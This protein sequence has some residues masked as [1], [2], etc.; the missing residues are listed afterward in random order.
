[1]SSNYVADDFS[2]GLDM[3]NDRSKL[4]K[5]GKYPLLINARSRNNR[6]RAVNKPRQLTEGLPSASQGYK[7]QGLY[8]AGNIGLVFV[9][10]N[11]FTCNFD[12]GEAF[13]KLEKF[14][15]SGDVDQLYMELI[16][17]ST[18]NYQRKAIDFTKPTDGVELFNSLAAPSPVGALVQDGINQP[19]IIFSDGNCRETQ[20]YY[21]WQNTDNGREYVPIGKQMVHSGDKLYITDGRQ[22]FQSVSGRPLDFMIIVDQN[23]DKAEFAADGDASNFS[24]RIFYELIN[25]LAKVNTDGEAGFYVGG[26][27]NSYICVPDYTQTAFNEP[28]RFKNK[29]IANKGAINQFCFVSDVDGDSVF[30]H[31]GSLIS[32]NSILNFK[33][34]GKNS[35]FSLLISN[36]F[37]KNVKQDISQACVGQFDNYTCYALNTTYGNVVLWFDELRNIWDGIDIWTEDELSGSIRQFAEITLSDGSNKLICLTTTGK[38][39]E[40]FGSSDSATAQMY[41][42]DFNTGDPAQ[43]QKL[44]QIKSLFDKPESDGMVNATLFVN[45]KRLTTLSKPV[46]K[47]FTPEEDATTVIPFGDDASNSVV[48]LTFDFGRSISGYKFGVLLEWNFI[49]NLLSVS[50]T[51]VETTEMANETSQKVVDFAETKKFLDART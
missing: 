39:Y 10:G 8:S 44:G 13:Y 23:G 21:Q 50:S 29:Y 46:S 47:L 30:V 37:N 45:N 19:W 17:A 49:G 40:Y 11:A 41:I 20:D 33:N 4:V 35:P 6:I 24:H 16:P 42:G 9:G 31:R 32:F 14:Q 22:I 38:V 12:N 18:V 48:P 34:A 3:F 27:N 25:C 7:Y 1:M 28:I 15:M 26:N 51:K 5:T 43:S 2:G 36:L